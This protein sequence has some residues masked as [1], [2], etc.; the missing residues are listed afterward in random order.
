MQVNPYLSFN[1]QCEEAFGFYAQLLGGQI[2]TLM[3]YGGSPMEAHAP[4]GARGK[5][6]HGRVAVAGQVLMG[7]D[8]VGDMAYE[9]PRGMTISLSI[10]DPAE[11]ERIFAALAEGGTIGMPIQETFWATRFGVTTDRFGIPWMVNCEKAANP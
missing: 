2:Q 3:T 4:A 10:A 11:A 7:S 6:M 5:V 9:A 8:S 1:G